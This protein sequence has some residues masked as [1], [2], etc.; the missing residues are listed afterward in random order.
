MNKDNN[1]FLNKENKTDVIELEES[2]NE[3]Y[4]QIILDDDDDEDC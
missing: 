3:N 1:L 2:D 4:E